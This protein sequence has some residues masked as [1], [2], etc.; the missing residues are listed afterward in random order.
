VRTADVEKV[1]SAAWNRKPARGL[2][3]EGP[4]EGAHAALVEVPLLAVMPS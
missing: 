3:D 4:G 2:V 1:G